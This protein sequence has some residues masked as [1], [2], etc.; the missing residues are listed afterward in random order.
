MTRDTC[1]GD[2]VSVS[3]VCLLSGW[4]GGFF[5][6]NILFWLVVIIAKNNSYKI[7]LETSAHVLWHCCYYCIC[8]V[9]GERKGYLLAK[10]QSDWL[11]A[12]EEQGCSVL[13]FIFTKVGATLA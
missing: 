13:V 11:F 4:I 5:I 7:D 8:F 3:G 12:V 10:E 6:V 2:N 1:L 9:L